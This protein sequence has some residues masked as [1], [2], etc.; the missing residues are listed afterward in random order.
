MAHLYAA[1]PESA[2]R[3]YCKAF[4]CIPCICAIVRCYGP[5]ERQY[6]VLSDVAYPFV[7]LS[8][9]GQLLLTPTNS[10]GFAADMTTEAGHAAPTMKRRGDVDQQ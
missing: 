5:T 2:H 6:P 3:T 9:F 4:E 10:D 8:V 1:M 7:M